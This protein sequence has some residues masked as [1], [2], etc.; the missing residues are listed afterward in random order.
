V[1]AALP[2]KAGATHLAFWSSA[3]VDRYRLLAAVISRLDSQGW[4]TKQDSGWADYDV[5]VL[6]NRW[7]KVRFITASEFLDRG[8]TVIRWRLQASWTFA[9]LASFWMAAAAQ[10]LL[11]GLLAETFPWIWM[12]LLS[13][14][15][16]S[17]FIE[18]L[19][20]RCVHGLTAQIQGVSGD[21]NMIPVN[22]AGVPTA[23]PMEA[24]ATG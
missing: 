13:L 22:E 7:A 4:Q 15:L 20:S 9:A 3:T 10:I 6:G 21:F 23:L 12:L 1:K 8:A 16:L 17:L 14:P 19:Q 24:P 5:E 2:I 11:V 18:Y